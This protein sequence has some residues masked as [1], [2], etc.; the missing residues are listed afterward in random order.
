M[1]KRRQSPD[2][3]QPALAAIGSL[4][5]LQRGSASYR[6]S[7]SVFAS[8]DNERMNPKESVCV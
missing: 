2:K 8:P 4:L 1:A 3:L 6:A 5:Y 7:F